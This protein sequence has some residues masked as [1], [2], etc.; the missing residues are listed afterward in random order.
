MTETNLR[1]AYAG[2]SQ[3]HMRYSHYAKR[4]KKEGFPNVSRLF[5]A[6]AFAELVHAGNHYRNIGSKGD[7]V[8]VS[9]AI[10]G[11]RSTS[12][13]LQAG[14]DGE[15]FEIEEMYPAY[16]KVAEFQKEKAAETSF[17]WALKAEKIHAS[18]YQKAKQAV[19][20]GKDVDLGP[21]Q[22]CT[23]CGYTVEGET[24]E[25]CPICS[26]LKEKFKTF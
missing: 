17:T 24:P 22:I 16:K 6:V 3:A 5:T 4:A 14:I 21:I 11:T 25:R 12:E 26:A 8:T 15:N 9:K 10:F 19:D 23:V 1:S 18:L 13:D 20:R 2:E 7:A